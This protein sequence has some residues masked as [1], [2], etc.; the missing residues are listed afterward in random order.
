MNAIPTIPSP[1]TTTFFLFFSPSALLPSAP[2]SS[3]L[4]GI[5]FASGSIHSS[6]AFLPSFPF[7]SPQVGFCGGDAGGECVSMLVG[8]RPG[9]GIGSGSAI[10]AVRKAFARCYKGGRS[11]NRQR[12]PER[13]NVR[14]DQSAQGRR[15]K[16]SRLGY[17][18][19]RPENKRK[20]AS[21]ESSKRTHASPRRTSPPTQAQRLPRPSLLQST[22]VC[23]PSIAHLRAA[24]ATPP[25][26]T[27]AEKRHVCA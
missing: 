24:C 20:N 27:D 21:T 4:S 6:F 1:T 3:T 7:F 2:P 22:R 17:R 14:R 25:S 16:E 11:S 15:C 9:V 8:S 18:A 23:K 5:P 10:A 19:A 26:P 13:R 12:K